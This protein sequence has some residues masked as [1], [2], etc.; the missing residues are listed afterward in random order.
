MKTAKSETAA[1]YLRRAS[2]SIETYG[3]SDTLGML[4]AELCGAALY[5]EGN[6]DEVTERLKE[7][8][9]HNKRQ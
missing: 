4:L 8:I 2:R 9:R 5:G 6:V 3:E 1:M 7:A